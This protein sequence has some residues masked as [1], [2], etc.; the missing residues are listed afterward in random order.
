MIKKINHVG[1][2]VH[3]LEDAVARYKKL[4]FAIDRI[5]TMPDFACRMAFLPCGESLIEL[6]Q[7]DE[8][9]H[10]EGL[11]HIC[12]EV[13]DIV[14]AFETVGARLPVRDP[15]PRAGAGRTK[16]FFME[17]ADLCGVETEFAEMPK[18]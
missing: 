18:T 6:I 1:I 17:P 4:G 8:P 10:S 3:D 16:V 2:V 7:P 12:Y 5:E 15:A 13:D 11:H 9:G 14:Q